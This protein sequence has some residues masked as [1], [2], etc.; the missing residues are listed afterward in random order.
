MQKCAIIFL[1]STKIF[2]IHPGSR[3]RDHLFKDRTEILLTTLK[4]IRKNY[5]TL[6]ENYDSFFLYEKTIPIKIL[7]FLKKS[8]IKFKLYDISSFIKNNKELK[9]HLYYLYLFI[10]KNKVARDFGYRVMIKLFSYYLYQI[11]I[12]KNYE[13][14]FRIDDDNFIMSEI[15]KK[16]DLVER[17]LDSNHVFSSR[18]FQKK[19]SFHN[20]LLNF[21]NNSYSI[22]IPDDYP[23]L[24][25]E[26]KSENNNFH[27]LPLTTFSLIKPKYFFNKDTDNLIKKIMDSNLVDYYRVGD[28]NIF[29]IIIKIFDHNI[30]PMSEYFKFDYAKW[31]FLFQK[32]Q[33]FREDSDIL[34]GGKFKSYVEAVNSDLQITKFRVD[35][36]NH[37]YYV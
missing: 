3:P 10:S 26:T 33:N 21:I 36:K 28:A 18:I 8:N 29:S 34:A 19:D 15:Q 2:T 12:F 17:F 5:P 9:Y 7:N 6:L 37:G 23:I 30:A 1:S 20:Y 13:C 32:F 22:K 11:E 25:N 27:P 14:L 24:N 4:S 16:D 31:G 35:K